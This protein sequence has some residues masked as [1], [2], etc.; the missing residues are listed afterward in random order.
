MRTSEYQP[1]DR[2]MPYTEALAAAIRGEIEGIATRSGHIKCLR[3][4][5]ASERPVVRPE[6]GAEIAPKGSSS[7]VVAQLN[8]GV[9][10]QEVESAVKDEWGAPT[11]II[12]GHVYAFCQ[13]RH[14]G[15]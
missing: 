10:R 6:T 2:A 4:L 11:R 8:M 12:I 7:G 9:Y 1:F 13:L 15:M 14:A 5:P 3:Q